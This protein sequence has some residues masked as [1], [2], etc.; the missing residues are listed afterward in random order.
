MCLH[1]V[2][3]VSLLEPYTTSSIMG[4]LTT[5]PPS[6]EF[7]EGPEFEVDVILDSKIVRNKLYYLI[8][9]L[10]YTPNDRTW[11]PARNLA[12]ATDMV[13]EFHRHYPRKLCPSAN[14]V[15]HDTY[16]RR[17]GIVS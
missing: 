10:G 3:H 16:H 14:H 11:E 4:H 1:P 13:T 5:L 12:N 7:F 17:R 8:Y 6:V 2:F 9:W 15:T